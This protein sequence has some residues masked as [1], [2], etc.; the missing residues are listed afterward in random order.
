MVMGDDPSCFVSLARLMSGV[1]A[2]TI[3]Y[4]IFLPDPRKISNLSNRDL[5]E[6]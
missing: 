4:E 6:G 2:V 1:R 5:Y 3:G